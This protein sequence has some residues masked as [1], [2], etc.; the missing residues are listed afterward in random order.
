VATERHD[1]G[2]LVKLPK[3]LP[4]GKLIRV[5]HKGGKKYVYVVVILGTNKEIEID[6][7]LIEKF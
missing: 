4:L 7:D 6:R 5:D 1:I 3:E 2:S